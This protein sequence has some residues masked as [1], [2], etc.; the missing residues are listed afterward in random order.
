MFRDEAR[1][2]VRAG[3]GGDGKISFRREKFIP[4]GGP[5]GGDGGRGGDVVLRATAQVNT[6]YD[7]ARRPA[8]RAQ[9]GGDGGAV[10]RHGAEQIPAARPLG[11]RPL[12]REPDHLAIGRER[13]ARHGQTRE[14]R[15]PSAPGWHAH[16]G[17]LR[18][19]RLAKPNGLTREP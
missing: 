4:K 2:T 15:G 5:D 1:I 13:S 7:V 8:Y 17:Q 19:H 11:P 9:N 3:R 16:L 14:T 18:M 6:L 10:D 12:R